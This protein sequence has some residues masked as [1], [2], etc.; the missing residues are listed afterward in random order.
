[1]TT[2][3]RTPRRAGK[4]KRH[5]VEM[6]VGL[7]L[8]DESLPQFRNHKTFLKAV[9]SPY[10]NPVIYADNPLMA[11]YASA[12]NLNTLRGSSSV[13]VYGHGRGRVIAMA[14]MPG[15]RGFFRGSMRL[16]NNAVFFGPIIE[17]R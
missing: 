9:N 2:L 16:F 11:G 3:S 7:G 15:F 4:R 10:S 5:F 14:E 8:P 1:M 17:A 12:A 13:S 6:I